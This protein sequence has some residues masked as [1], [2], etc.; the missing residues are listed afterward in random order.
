MKAG[1]VITV[2]ERPD[3]LSDT[4]NSLKNSM[5]PEWLDI[6]LYN[7]SSKNP[8]TNKIFNEFNLPNLS[9]I[10]SSKN[11]GINS[12][13][14]KGFDFFKNHELLLNLDSD[15]LLKPYWFNALFYLHTQ[16]PT[17]IITGFDT[18]TH[19]AIEY[20]SGY[21][22]KQSIGGINLLFHR[23]TLPLIQESLQEKDWDWAMC[24]KAH[25]KHLL[26]ATTPSVIEHIG[27]NSTMKHISDKASFWRY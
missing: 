14:Q 1:L 7:D 2:Y 11:S 10:T 20:F 24:K 8:L 25:N 4:F 9:K 23:S 21:C 18:L 15:V 22:I 13:L 3:L 19:P 5:L 27:D 6:L 12:S 16:H 26:I 17:A